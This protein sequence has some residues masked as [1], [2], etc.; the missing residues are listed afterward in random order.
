MKALLY[1]SHVVDTTLRQSLEME[2]CTLGAMASMDNLETAK[3]K[4][5]QQE[6]NHCVELADSQSE[7]LFLQ[8]P[9][10]AISVV[11]VFLRV[12]LVLPDGSRGMRAQVFYC[13]RF[14]L[15][16]VCFWE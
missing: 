10:L 8:G 5:L 14:L 13:C 1:P 6:P 2:C 15:S 12:F 7:A 3:T 16:S 4:C 11:D 9:L